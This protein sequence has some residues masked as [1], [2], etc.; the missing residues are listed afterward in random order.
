MEEVFD[1]LYATTPEALPGAAS[2]EIRSFLLRRETGALSNSAQR[3][4]KNRSDS[5]P[6]RPDD[7][8]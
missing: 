6:A 3:P 2:L 8:S 5:L 1:Q 4:G 7:T